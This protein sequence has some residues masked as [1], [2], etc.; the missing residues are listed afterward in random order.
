MIRIDER[1]KMNVKPYLKAIVALLGAIGT[2]G[3]TAASDGSIDL[4]EAFAAL[5]AI[6]TALGVFIVPNEEV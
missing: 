2:W 1:K 3:V 4:S 5:A 6:A